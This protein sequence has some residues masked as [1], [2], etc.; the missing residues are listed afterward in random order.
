VKKAVQWDPTIVEWDR[1]GTQ[2][3][4]DSEGLNGIR[5]A[6]WTQIVNNYTKHRRIR[7]RLDTAVSSLF[8]GAQTEGGR[9]SEK[10]EEIQNFSSDTFQRPEQGSKSRKERRVI[11]L[12]REDEPGEEDQDKVREL[13]K[14][15]WDGWR[16]M[17]GTQEVCQAC[18]EASSG[19]CAI[20][21]P[22]EE[23][24]VLSVGMKDASRESNSRSEDIG[25]SCTENREGTSKLQLPLAH[26]KVPTELS[27][28]E[29][30]SRGVNKIPL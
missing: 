16:I 25:P 10:S 6:R 21:V 2:W 28:T 22:T 1:E 19:C 20:G 4:V 5:S 8:G 23:G 30:R 12:G 3:R 29:Q 13:T 14:S 18:N 7:G 27:A 11:D 15:P 26:R 9:V 17:E 24:E